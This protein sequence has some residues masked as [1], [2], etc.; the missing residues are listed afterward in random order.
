MT[1]ICINNLLSKTFLTKPYTFMNGISLPN[2]GFRNFSADLPFIPKAAYDKAV[3]FYENFAL[4][5]QNFKQVLANKSEELKRLKLK[6]EKTGSQGL[7]EIIQRKEATIESMNKLF[8]QFREG[9][10]EE[11]NSIVEQVNAYMGIA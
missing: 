3:G 6:Y 4:Q 1:L 10:F 5:G 11:A 9:Y 7:A 8:D 2:N